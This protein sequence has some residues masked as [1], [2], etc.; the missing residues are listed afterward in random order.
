MPA[1]VA[2]A[3]A[4]D[5][6]DTLTVT[7]ATFLALVVVWLALLVDVWTLRRERT[8]ADADEALSTVV[9][10]FLV[11]LADM[12]AEDAVLLI[13]ETFREILVSIV[14]EDAVADLALTVT[15]TP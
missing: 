9:V 8:E 3:L 2:L 13:V 12:A 7:A 11:T 5:V 6:E 4:E 1:V 15:V 10:T 14:D